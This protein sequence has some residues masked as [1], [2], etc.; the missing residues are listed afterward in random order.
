MI[1]LLKRESW[2][3][4]KFALIGVAATLVHSLIYSAC[5]RFDWAGPQWAN[6]S[7]FL[8]A[9]FVSFFGHHYWTFQ[10]GA[11]RWPNPLLLVRFLLTSLLTYLLN[12]FWVW[13]VGDLLHWHPQLAVVGIMLLTPAA[14][15]LL[16]R[17]FVFK[18]RLKHDPA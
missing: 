4:S 18:V 15:Y 7:G 8:C 14:S 11:N 16:F 13:A 5:I 12:A 1:E 6:S 17:N 2:Q 10:A 9:W 3:I